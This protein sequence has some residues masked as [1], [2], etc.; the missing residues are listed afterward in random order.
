MSEM[1][2]ETHVGMGLVKPLEDSPSTIAPPSSPIP[3]ANPIHLQL[4]QVQG[5]PSY[6]KKSWPLASGL[7]K[8]PR[9]VKGN[10]FQLIIKQALVSL[11]QW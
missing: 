6:H 7:S 10:D 1:I 11:L 4:L 8:S 5:P 9:V 2:S 3:W